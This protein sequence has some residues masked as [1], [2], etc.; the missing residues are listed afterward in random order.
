MKLFVWANPYSVSYGTSAVFAVAET[1]EEAR[2]AAKAG[3]GYAFVE[4]NQPVPDAAQIP[5][6]EPTRVVE[7]NGPVAEWHEWSE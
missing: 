5:L 7:I 1:I 4:F 2:E 3:T 6:G